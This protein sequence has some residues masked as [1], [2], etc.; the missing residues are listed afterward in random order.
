MRGMS[1]HFAEYISL[2]RRFFRTYA[3]LLIAMAV[4]AVVMLGGFFGLSN[5]PW[6]GIVVFAAGCAMAVSAARN[7]I[8][9]YRLMSWPCPRCDKLFIVAWWSSWPTN[10]CK[11]CGLNVESP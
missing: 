6:F 1:S 10:E 8:A 9:W 7:A 2:R 5:Q 4:I 3:A 11:H